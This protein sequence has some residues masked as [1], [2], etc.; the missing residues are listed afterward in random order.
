MDCARCATRFEYYDLACSNCGAPREEPDPVAAAP[1]TWPPPEPEPGDEPVV[2]RAAAGAV[3]STT[4]GA[5]RDAQ[6]GD[7]L[8]LLLTAAGACGLGFEFRASVE[9][10]RAWHYGGWVGDSSGT[11][12]SALLMSVPVVLAAFA[13]TFTRVPAAGAVV[14]GV[15]LIAMYSQPGLEADRS[16]FAGLL[17]GGFLLGDLVLFLARRSRGFLVS[18]GAAL[19]AAGGLTA[20]HLAA[21]VQNF[22]DLDHFADRTL[23]E[24]YLLPGGLLLAAGILGALVGRAVHRPWIRRP[25]PVSRGPAGARRARR[26]SSR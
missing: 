14:A 24:Y 26:G 17:V 13:A 12:E 21:A 19:L 15:S 22:P 6:L 4:R 3:P 9:E 23:R 20:W 7:L 2:A 11:R 10:F 1:Q 25:Q 5:G 8:V 18:V 16:W